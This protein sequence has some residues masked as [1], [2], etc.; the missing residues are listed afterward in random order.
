LIV[1]CTESF[2]ADGWEVNIGLCATAEFT[3]DNQD[4]P[5]WLD[6]LLS[7]DNVQVAHTCA[8]TIARAWGIPCWQHSGAV[9]KRSERLC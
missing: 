1:L 8:M 5:S 4:W 3:P 9:D 6:F 7:T 2:S